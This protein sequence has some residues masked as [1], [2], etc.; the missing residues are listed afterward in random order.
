MNDYI[1]ALDQ[2]TTSSRAILFDVE[3]QI[4][5]SA[6]Q[7]LPQ[8]YPQAG[9]VEHDPSAIWQ[10]QYA[11]IQAVLKETAVA[12]E[13]IAAVGITN[14][15]ETSLAWQ[16][17]TGVPL[18]NAIVWQCRRTAGRCQE[19]E[20]QGLA[21]TVRQKTG[22]VLD[23]YFS[24]PKFEWIL[25][26]VPR[27]RELAVRNDLC[28]GTVDS[29]LIAQLTGHAQHVTDPTNASRTMLYDIHARDWDAGLL[30]LFGISRAAMPQVVP[31]SGVVGHTDPA[32]FGAATPIAGIAGDQQAALFGQTC[33]QPG[34]AKNTYGTGCFLLSHTGD[35]ATPSE[36][37]L[38][39]T[40]AASAD[41]P[42]YALEGSV[43]V[44]G[45]AIQWLRDKL[46]VIA[47][48]GE[49]E[50]LA[51]QVPNTGGVVVVPAFTGLGTPYWDPEARGTILG[52]TLGS[53]KA[54]V[55]RATLESIAFQ[56]RDVVQTMQAESGVALQELRADGGAVANDLLMQTQADLL[57]IPVVVPA[58]T[59]T[60]ALGA[61]YL[62]GLGVGYWPDAA[63]VAAQWRVARRYEPQISADERESRY[64]TWRR[65]VE[66]SRQ[67]AAT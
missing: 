56:T 1:L 62:A 5:A 4:V 63:A 33:W 46:G 61:A 25:Q 9:W 40:V 38:L 14:Q 22:L 11:C 31:S 6:G 51:R 28:L 42:A 52:L 37:G 49:S 3:G 10:T 47:T 21:D 32:V 16:R 39:T 65:A 18:G 58:V 57:G 54:H 7:E 27:A 13:Q 30:A 34:H 55:V 15:R 36:T 53:T 45:A 2:G 8:I 50:D 19:L 43:F 17:S 29:W 23:A 48:A 44:A 41:A 59:E 66:R 64:A 60:T 35:E 67:W 20:A 24:G 26:N 12:P